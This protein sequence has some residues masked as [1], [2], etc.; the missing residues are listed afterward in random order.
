MKLLLLT[1]YWPPA[2]GAGVQRWLRMS[3]ELTHRGHEL[4]VITT[5]HGDYPQMDP[6]LLRDVPAAVR[7]LRTHTPTFGGIFRRFAGKKQTIPFGSM[8]SQTGDSLAKK[9]LLWIRRN[10][11][12]PD[13]RVIWNPSAYRATLKELRRGGYDVLIT[14]GP[15]QSTHLVGHRLHKERRIPWIADFRDPWSAVVYILDTSPWK[16]V[17]ALQQGLER[18]VCRDAD[19]VMTVSQAIADELPAGNKLVLHNGFLGEEF[20]GL[21]YTRT[22]RFRMKYIGTLT[23]GRD[24]TPLLNAAET[25][26]A[27]GAPITFQLVG[28]L[29]ELPADW[30]SRYPHVEFVVKPFVAHREALQEMVD[31]EALL[32]VVNRYAGS[33]GFL[34]MKLFE[35]M[36]SRTQVLGLGP[37]DSEAAEL[38]REYSAGTLVDYADEAGLITA[39]QTMVNAWRE[40]IALRTTGELS[41]L[42]VECLAGQFI[43]TVTSILRNAGKKKQHHSAV[44]NG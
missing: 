30:S 22:G 33:R 31:A 3:R 20:T 44:E 11:V 13:A 12:V 21:Q 25:V 26:A 14:T 2:G 29:P 15:P 8:R 36:G 32:L 38:L 9:A 19:I 17:L 7:V 6:E 16:P 27:T 4:T 18:G 39:L 10:L 5:N 23:E 40:G 43:D 41:T 37:L 28:T 1:Y 24:V 35:Y 42:T 34:T